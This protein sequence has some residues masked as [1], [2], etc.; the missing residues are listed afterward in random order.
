M[1]DRRSVTIRHSCD[2]K[3]SLKIK[4]INSG[5][6][7]IVGSFSD[8]ENP[9]AIYIGKMAE[10]GFM[11]KDVWLDVESA[12]VVYI[13]GSRRGGKS[14]TLGVLAEGLVS[15]ELSLSPPENA[16]LM[17]DTL[18][19]FWTMKMSSSNG[20]QSED[21]K[22]WGL[23]DKKIKN[24]QIFYP[25]GL[26]KEW[27]D[28]YDFKEFSISTSDL[29][30]YDITDLFE[31]N[32]IT[33]PQGQIITEIF[34]KVTERGYSTRTGAI[35]E[36][37]R[38]FSFIDLIRC[39][40]GDLD[41]ERFPPN[42]REAV[43][44]RISAL[45]REEIFSPDGTHVNDLFVK[46][47]ITNILLMDLNSQI[48]GLVI[49][50]LVRKIFQSRGI[51]AQ[52]EKKFEILSNN[53]E[54]S[55]ETLEEIK[56]KIKFGTPRGWILMDEGHNYMPANH[57]IGSLKPL[58]QYVNEGRNLGLSMATTT[59]NPAGIH[60]SV[61]RNADIIIV[62]KIGI[63]S[64]IKAAEGMLRNNVPEKV[65]FRGGDTFDKKIFEKVVRDEKIGYALISSDN[66]S[67]VIY[68]NIR[69]RITIHG[70]LNY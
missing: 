38:S 3:T 67:R 34:E 45:E 20:Q 56:K 32:S 27:M 60:S 25:K 17:F 2:F 41:L 61:Q 14:Y 15:E 11:N 28:E 22:Q 54:T 37:N 40:D 68:V 42:S 18:N 30:S 21:V 66:S 7:I 8:S 10:A 12:H 33:D 29:T 51:S 47:Q 23:Q 24:I 4:S 36:A 6:D 62:H 55:S 5:K 63:D 65:Y 53:P 50:V 9:K 39:L 1:I 26:K 13:I 31:L 69:P 16:V 58:I 52:N 19:L 64:D 48:R 59:Q 43:R 49:G 35:V 44:R 57:Q 46:G 70:G